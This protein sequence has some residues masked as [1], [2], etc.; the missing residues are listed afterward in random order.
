[1]TDGVSGST[2]PRRQL[3][4]YLRDLR[5]QAR[6]TVRAAASALEWSDAKIWRIETGQ[7]SMRSLDVE[8]MCRVYGAPSDLT[9]SLMA[10]AKET[11]ARGWW[12]SYSDVINEGFDVYIGLEEAAASLFW[13]EAELVPGLFQTADYTR[14]L[15][16]AAKPNLDAEEVDRR[17]QLRITRQKLLTRATHPPELRVVLNEAILRRPVGGR[18]VM[19]G[20]LKGLVEASDLP[21]VSI[22]VMPF[23][24]GLHYGIMSGP[25]VL[26]EFPV[27]GNG[28]QTE[29]PT[30]YVDSFTGALFL[31]KPNEI[32][33]YSEAF[34]DMWTA[35]ISASESRNFIADVAKEMNE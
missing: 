8:Q 25:F 5:G 11:K 20:Q 33:R 4:R 9:E 16:T 6:L 3:G 7:T 13:Y 35:A 24:I 17:V 34:K 26:L 29:P 14:T 19:A 28:Q 23:D 30:V 32:E 27:N 12:L 22:K 10:L 18:N 21:N 31:D 15:I 2:V 1:M